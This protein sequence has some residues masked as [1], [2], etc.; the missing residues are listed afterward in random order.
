[1]NFDS[2]DVDLKLNIYNHSNS[3]VFYFSNENNVYAFDVIEKSLEAGSKV[4]DFLDILNNRNSCPIFPCSC[5]VDAG[6]AAGVIPAL[7]SLQ[8]LDT[9]PINEMQML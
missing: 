9:R 8:E 4:S 3:A 7:F 6:I 2:H 5:P 1:M